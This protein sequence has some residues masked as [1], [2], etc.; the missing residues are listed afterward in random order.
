[1]ITTNINTICDLDISEELKKDT[2]LREIFI[3]VMTGKWPEKNKNVK[4]ELKPYF[5]NEL[6]VD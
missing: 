6:S 2:F 4:I 1:M 5:Y 3:R